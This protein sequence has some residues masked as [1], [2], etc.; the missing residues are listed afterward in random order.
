LGSSSVLGMIYKQRW[1]QEKS[2]CGGRMPGVV[3]CQRGGFS[4]CCFLIKGYLMAGWPIRLEIFTGW[5]T[6]SADRSCMWVGWP[7]GPFSN[8]CFAA[9]RSRNELRSQAGRLTKA[10][11][12]ILVIPTKSCSLQDGLNITSERRFWHLEGQNRHRGRVCRD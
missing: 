1:V 7:E 4:G 11:L 6:G 2:Q 5:A 12:M 8:S 9:T 3:D 10:A